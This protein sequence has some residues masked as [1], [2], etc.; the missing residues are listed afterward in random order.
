MNYLKSD[1]GDNFINDKYILP[2][3]KISNIK[4]IVSYEWSSEQK[5]YDINDKYKIEWHDEELDVSDLSPTLLFIAINNTYKRDFGLFIPTDMSISK[6]SKYI[7]KNLNDGNKYIF[8]GFEYID[9]EYL[10]NMGKIKST[11]IWNSKALRHGNVYVYD[12]LTS[13][14]IQAIIRNCRKF[15]NKLLDD[16]KI[17]DKKY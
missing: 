6:F 16:N 8:N 9:L 13:G 4:D 3:N 11:K 1:N 5:S 14:T 2:F 7:I 12:K 17:I 10:N 15:Q